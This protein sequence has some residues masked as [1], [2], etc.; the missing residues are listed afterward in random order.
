[1][2]NSAEYKIYSLLDSQDLSKQKFGLHHERDFKLALKWARERIPT[3][4]GRIYNVSACFYTKTE[5]NEFIYK[6]NPDGVHYC[7]GL[8]GEGFKFMPVHGKIVHDGLI[9]GKDTTYIRQVRAKI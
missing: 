3:K 4:F 1:M 6:T 9:T 2:K 5:S 7:Y 8:C